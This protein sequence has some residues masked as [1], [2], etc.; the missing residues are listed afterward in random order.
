M[1]KQQLFFLTIII[2]IAIL[3]VTIYLSK[4]APVQEVEPIQEEGDC[5]VMTSKK[6]QQKKNRYQAKGDIKFSPVKRKGKYNAKLS[7][8]KIEVTPDGTCLLAYGDFQ[9]DRFSATWSRSYMTGVGGY[10]LTWGPSIMQ[11]GTQ[12]MFGESILFQRQFAIISQADFIADGDEFLRSRE[13]IIPCDDNES[14]VD[15]YYRTPATTPLKVFPIDNWEEVTSFTAG[16]TLVGNVINFT[17][18]DLVSGPDQYIVAVTIPLAN[19]TIFRGTFAP[20]VPAGNSVDVQL[21]AEEL[22]E[23]VDPEL[24]NSWFSAKIYGFTDA[25]LGDSAA[26]SATVMF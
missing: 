16:F 20:A 12:G 3:V 22:S 11:Y 13:A 6:L 2:V 15:E 18:S 21:Y 8:G 5:A 26:G 4:P 23:I 7:T 24:S 17:F 9:A 19:Y 10:V 25:N 14:V 1:D